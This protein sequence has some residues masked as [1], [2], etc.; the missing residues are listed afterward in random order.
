MNYIIDNLPNLTAE[1]VIRMSVTHVLGNGRPSI[2]EDT[3][4]DK[5]PVCTYAGIGCAAAPFIKPE[6]RAAPELRNKTWVY[7]SRADDCL[8]HNHL[9]NSLQNCH[10]QASQ[11]NDFIGSYKANLEA[12]LHEAFDGQ[13]DTLV[14]ELIA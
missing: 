4:D 11:T 6:K 7:I 9:I 5:R 2:E 10:D 1:A 8:E 13:Y 14:K 3:T 12:Y